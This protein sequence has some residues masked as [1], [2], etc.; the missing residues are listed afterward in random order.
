MLNPFLWISDVLDDMFVS[1]LC[2]LPSLPFYPHWS[3]S[4]QYVYASVCRSHAVGRCWMFPKSVLINNNIFTLFLLQFIFKNFASIF[5][6]QCFLNRYKFLIKALS[7]LLNGTLGLHD[8]YT[9][10]ALKIIIYDNIICFC[11]QTSEYKTK[12]N[13]V[14]LK[15][16][17]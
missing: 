5:R 17:F 16:N 15:F 6:K 2:G 13:L 7:S 9:F 14:L 3:R 1:G 11:L 10:N 8:R 4:L 12:H